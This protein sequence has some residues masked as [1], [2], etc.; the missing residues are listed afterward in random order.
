MRQGLAL[1]FA[2]NLVTLP[3]MFYHFH[4]FPFL[5]LLYNLFFPAM[6]SIS[7]FLLLFP[8]F[9]GLNQLF[10]KFML[11]LTYNMPPA[12]DIVWRVENFPIEVVVGVLSLLLLYVMRREESRV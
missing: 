4:R 12:L 5:G 9:V 11:N 1:G 2:V 8:P 3:M 10:T 7:M 6:V